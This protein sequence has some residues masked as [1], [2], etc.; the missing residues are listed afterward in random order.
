VSNGEYL[1]FVEAGGYERPEL[2]LHE[3][4]ETLRKQNWHAPLYWER[5]DGQW[6]F[7]TL[8]GLRE[9]SRDEPVC[10]LSYFEAE[11]YARYAQ[12]RLP[13]EYEWEWAAAGI[14][15]EGNFL[16][17]DQLHPDASLESNTRGLHQLYGDVWEWTSSSHTPYPGFKGSE[18]EPARYKD[19]HTF[20]CNRMVLRGGSCATP[21]AHI[22]PSYRNFLAPG[23]RWQFSGLRLARDA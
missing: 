10:H 8:H 22:R 12:A 20:M 13:T 3:G 7:Y 9:L 18:G 5:H 14:P 19:M 6:Q 23:A 17:N 1:E 11:A 21:R 2:W 15:L 4:W 16:E